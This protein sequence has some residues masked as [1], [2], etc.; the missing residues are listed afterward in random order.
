MATTGCATCLPVAAGASGSGLWRLL[1]V[2]PAVA[3]RRRRLR[4]A[5]TAWR[6]A[7]AGR[8]G[9]RRGRPGRPARASRRARSVRSGPSGRGEIDRWGAAAPFWSLARRS[10]APP[11]WRRVSTSAFRT[12]TAGSWSWCWGS[13]RRSAL[14]AAGE[15]VAAAAGARRPAPGGSCGAA[16][17]P[18]TSC[19]GR[20]RACLGEQRDP[21]FAINCVGRART[22]GPV[23]ASRLAATD[24]SIGAGAAGGCRSG[25][26]LSRPAGLVRL[27]RRVL[28]YEE[29]S[30]NGD[31]RDRMGDEFAPETE[32]DP[33]AG[34]CRGLT[35]AVRKRR[36]SEPRLR[37]LGD[38]RDVTCGSTGPS[39]ESGSTRFTG[40]LTGGPRRGSAPLP[41]S[42]DPP[43]RPRCS[44]G[45]SSRSGASLPGRWPRSRCA[46]PLG[47]LAPFGSASRPAAPVCLLRGEASRCRT[48]ERPLRSCSRLPGWARAPCVAQ[49]FPRRGPPPRIRGLRR[50]RDRRRRAPRRRPAPWP[51]AS[52][53][54]SAKRPSW[55]RGSSSPWPSEAPGA[56]TPAP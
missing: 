19:A 35:E 11:G 31:E 29:H 51:P 10:S 55:V 42:P 37:R 2:G 15:Q 45:P 16:S 34:R 46:P 3:G 21:A 40:P 28:D 12:A 43:P 32:R 44:R 49:R 27:G 13:P 52:P 33:P 20:T 25:L 9:R 41:S 17:V 39:I 1:R 50:A 7:A 5:A 38:L 18:P 47:A 36:Y 24:V 6:V 54:R 53:S 26:A 30:M 23:C 56:S 4:A 14:P 8:S 22:L 48:P